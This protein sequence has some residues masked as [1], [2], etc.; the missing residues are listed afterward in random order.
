MEKKWWPF[1]SAVWHIAQDHT[2][3]RKKAH[4]GFLSELCDH[5]FSVPFLCQQPEWKKS[6]LVNIWFDHRVFWCAYRQRHK[7]TVPKHSWLT[8]C[9]KK[10][11]LKCQAAFRHICHYS[12]TVQCTVSYLLNW[13]FQYTSTTV[14]TNMREPKVMFTDWQAYICYYCIIR[15]SKSG[16][17]CQSKLCST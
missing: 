15:V 16:C 8:L 6:K 11:G 3:H 13:W 12:T 4:S 7:E 1:F 10:I 17:S 9:P 2:L 5:S 14:T